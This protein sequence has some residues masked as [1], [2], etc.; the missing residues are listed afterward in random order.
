M[1]FSEKA[2]GVIFEAFPTI[3]GCHGDFGGV[4]GGHVKETGRRQAKRGS[5]PDY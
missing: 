4:L 1:T 2:A 3:W 5:Q